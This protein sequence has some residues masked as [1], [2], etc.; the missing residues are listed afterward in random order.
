M[1]NE[2]RYMPWNSG[3]HMAAIEML[4]AEVSEEEVS[5]EEMLTMFSV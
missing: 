1:Y 3:Y 2:L 4:M 5:A